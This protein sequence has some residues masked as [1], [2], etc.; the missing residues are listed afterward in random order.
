M[1]D[2]I[3][4]SVVSKYKHRSKAGIE[5]YGTTL[6]QNNLSFE[7]WLTHLQEELMDATLYIEKMKQILFLAIIATF[8]ACDKSGDTCD[9]QCGIIRDK[10]ISFSHSMG[11]N[12]YRYTI[13]NECSGAR[14]SVSGYSSIPYDDHLI[15]DRI[16]RTDIW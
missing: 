8:T 14:Y 6:E 3:V 7:K 15:G 12:V 11:S 1:N 16:C 4:E 9:P 13:D 10:S 2:P 5:K